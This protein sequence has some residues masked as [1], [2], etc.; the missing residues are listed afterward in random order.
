MTTCEFLDAI[1]AR[2][3]LPSDYALAHFT[4]I[5]KAGISGYRKGKSRLDDANA[6]KVASLLELNPGYVLA[7]IHAERAKSD[8]VRETWQRTAKALMLDR[9][10]DG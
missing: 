2:Y 1:K 7:C 6:I 9:L 4:G 3:G 8:D 5:G 10:L